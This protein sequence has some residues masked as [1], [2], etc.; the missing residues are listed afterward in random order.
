MIEAVIFD[1]DN[2][3]VNRKLAF[4]GFTE[5]LIDKY[6]VVNSS[7]EREGLISYIREAD[8]DGY[9]S[10]KELYA[11]LLEKLEWKKETSVDELLDFWHSE[12]YKY[13]T[14]MEDAIE[15]I[16]FIKENQIRLGIITNGSV[17]SQN[18][19]IDQ[20]GIRKFF[21]AIVIS[22]AVN[23]KKPDKKIF[24]YTLQQLNVRAERSY[25]I[26]DH[27]INDIIGAEDAGLNAIWLE[28]FR[29][30][31][32]SLPGPRKKIS[33]LVE[34]IQIIEGNK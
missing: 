21:D 32:D 18:A 17:H 11:E 6:L 15:V 16:Q 29:V 8:R 12:F 1:L 5:K 13:T 10:K 20:V 7:A 9:R 30:W 34:L 28:G 23:V 33:K 3:L 22:D 14:L 31:E 19:K 24:E 2:T 26:G 4:R 25:Y 27:P